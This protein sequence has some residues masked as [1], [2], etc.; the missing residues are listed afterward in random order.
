MIRRF[1]AKP[2]STRI[3]PANARV[4]ILDAVAFG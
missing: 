3:T 2:F 1:R 4:D